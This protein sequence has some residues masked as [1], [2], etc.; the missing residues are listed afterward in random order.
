MSFEIYFDESHKLDR[1]TSNYSYYGAIGWD[2]TIREKFDNYIENLNIRNELHFREFQL[3]KIEKYLNAT[4]DALSKI[5]GNFFIVDTKEAFRVCERIGIDKKQLRAL[6]YIKIPER[7]IYGITRRIERFNTVD[8]YIDESEEYNDDKLGLERKL[9]EQL[10]AQSVYRELQ[11]VVDK[12][13]QI[14]SKK[15]RSIQITDVITGIIAF[16]FE[17][18]YLNPPQSIEYKKMDEILSGNLISED[19][20]QV[21]KRVYTYKKYER[22][23]KSKYNLEMDKDDEDTTIKLKDIARKYKLYSQDTI[24]KSEFIYRLLMNKENI[25]KFENLSLFLWSSNRN[26]LNGDISNNI[27]KNYSIKEIEKES[28]AKYIAYFIKFK[29]EYDNYNRIKILNFY[30]DDKKEYKTEKEYNKYLGF[31]SGLKQLT[32]RYLNELGIDTIK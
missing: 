31:G 32:R 15:S 14:D 5:H 29:V 20:K 24:K 13:I 12:V 7:L 27:L 23:G 18:K 22:S 26:E 2:K 6:F 8:I 25:E 16:L 11:Y 17:E 1:Q 3:D 28:I 30:Y 10:N 4:E 19:D 21:L 9:K